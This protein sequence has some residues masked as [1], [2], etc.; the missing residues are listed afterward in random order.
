MKLIKYCGK[1]IKKYRSSF[2]GECKGHSMVDLVQ[3]VPIKEVRIAEEQHHAMHALTFLHFMIVRTIRGERLKRRLLGRAIR[4]LADLRE[5]LEDG[6][7]SVLVNDLLK[8]LEYEYDK[9]LFSLVRGLHRWIRGMIATLM[10]GEGE[11]I[12]SRT[13]SIFISL[14]EN[15]SHAALSMYPWFFRNEDKVLRFAEHYGK[16]EIFKG[17]LPIPERVGFGSQKEKKES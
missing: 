6:T 9:S 16:K 12:L 4:H 17:F 14:S 5:F 10:G 15:D 1:E 3:M 7:L 8:S 2:L 13:T 11:H